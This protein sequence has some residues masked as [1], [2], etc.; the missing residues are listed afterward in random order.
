M[1]SFISIA[2]IAIILFA[3]SCNSNNEKTTENQTSTNTETTESSDNKTEIP[4]NAKF[5]MT[6]YN[7]SML[8]SL[9]YEGDIILGKSWNDASGENVFIMCEKGSYNNKE[10]TQSKYLNAYHYANSGNGWKLLR[11]IHDFEEKCDAAMNA[12]FSTKSLNIT[13]LDNDNYAEITFVYRLGCNGDPSPVPLKLMM[14]EKGEKYA[15]RG[16]TLVDGKIYGRTDNLGGE[17]KVDAS[18]NNA[19][20]GFLDFANELWEAEKWH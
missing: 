14:L 18:F 8:N 6:V 1:K 11:K 12:E 7:A 17:K 20:K 4:K 13:D 2:V 10:Q 19:P 5:E 3:A 9:E 15:I 16:T